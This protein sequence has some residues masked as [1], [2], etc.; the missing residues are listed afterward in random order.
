MKSLNEQLFER[1]MR[2]PHDMR[3]RMMEEHMNED[4][5]LRGMPPRPP[6][7]PGRPMPMPF[8]RGMEGDPARTMPF[9]GQGGI[10]GALRPLPFRGGRPGGFD[11]RPEGQPG[12][13]RG[14]AMLN[15]ERVLDVLLNGADGGMRQKE[16]AA[17]LRV[18]PSTISEFIALL[19]QSGYVTREVDPNDRRA[20]VIKLTDVGRARACELADERDDRYARV[21]SVLN[22]DEKRQLIALID[23][24]TLPAR[25]PEHRTQLV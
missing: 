16:I 22:D 8:R 15:R 17:E 18:G 19:E 14:P 11:G 5:R 25:G 3:S 6:H 1:I 9:H 21:F 12:H 20:T 4:A 23:K 24:L 13:G 10:E 2:L 7:D